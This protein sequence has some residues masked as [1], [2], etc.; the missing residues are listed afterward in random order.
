MF[1]M[2]EICTLSGCEPGFI[3]WWLLLCLGCARARVSVLFIGCLVRIICSFFDFLVQAAAR[4]ATAASLPS[5]IFKFPTA[6]L[7]SPQHG[8]TRFPEIDFNQS[9]SLYLATALLGGCEHRW[10]EYRCFVRAASAHSD[11]SVALF[12]TVTPVCMLWITVTTYI[13]L[14][15]ASVNETG[16]HSVCSLPDCAALGFSTQWPF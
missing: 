12:L 6:K 13:R 7:L 14:K 11:A 16:Q 4:R 9:H 1:G 8:R 10:F 2:L 15:I 5:S 3:S